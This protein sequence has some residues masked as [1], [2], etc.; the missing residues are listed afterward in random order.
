MKLHPTRG[1]LLCLSGPSKLMNQALV[2]D[3]FN[4][5]ISA[6]GVLQQAKVPAHHQAKM[7]NGMLEKATFKFTLRRKEVAGEIMA[8]GPYPYLDLG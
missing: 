2:V 3:E 7:R 1:A 4:S 6:I 8:E 5:C